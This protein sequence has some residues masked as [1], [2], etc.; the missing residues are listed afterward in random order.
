MVN[1]KNI[2]SLNLSCLVNSLLCLFI[3]FFCHNL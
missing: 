2:F 3:I 1:S